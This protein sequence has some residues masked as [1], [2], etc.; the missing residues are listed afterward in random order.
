MRAPLLPL[1][2]P[3]RQGVA[4]HHEPHVQ[5]REHPER[6]QQRDQHAPRQRGGARLEHDGLGVQG[7]E[8]V[9]AEVNERHET[10]PADAE[11]RGVAGPQRRILDRT[12]QQ[13]IPDIK[14]EEKQRGREPGVPR[15]PR[16]P[17]RLPPDG[18][19]REH[20][21]GEHRPRFRR[22]R[23]EAVQPW[24]L[25]E[26][27]EDP[28]QPDQEHGRFGPDGRRDVEVVD[29]LR[30]S[31]QPLD[32]CERQGPDIDEGEQ[33]QP[34]Q[35]DQPA[36]PSETHSSTVNG[37]RSVASVTNAMSYA[38]S[39]LSHPADSLKGR[40]PSRRAVTCTAPMSGGRRKGSRSTT[41]SSSAKRVRITSALNN[42][43]T[44][45]KPTV[46]SAITAIR[47]PSTG[48]TGTSKKRTNSGSPTTSTT[49]TNTRLA[50]SFPQ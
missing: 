15:P 6:Q 46:A 12:P 1:L 3:E 44:A 2:L 5:E 30:R 27:V 14:E 18:T 43:P 17:D 40:P 48:A 42:V 36:R 7:A 16:P 49:A 20:D 9:H 50:S 39:N 25:Q 29:L 10:H 8:Q 11:H 45:T 23:S 35:G 4:L 22:R 13:Q 41:S 47:G 26:Q 28:R 33:P 34:Q 19:G 21:R 37:K 38:A 24:V 32:R 31:L